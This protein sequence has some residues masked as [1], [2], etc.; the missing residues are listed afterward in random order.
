MLQ[1]LL[2]RG[3]SYDDI[4]SLLG[5]SREDVRRKAR[6][7]LEELG[8]RDPDAE[9]GLSD[10]LLGQ[11]DPIGR[12]DVVRHLQADPEA[13]G[14]AGELSAK[15]RLLAPEAELPDLPQPKKRRGA[16][17]A[18]AGA[19]PGAPS[20]GRESEEKRSPIAGLSTRQSRLIAI[21]GASAVIVLIA[22]VA[23]LSGG[24][25]GDSNSATSDE[26]EPDVDRIEF[27]AQSG[28]GASGE[29]IIGFANQTTPFLELDLSGLPEAGKG[30]A[31]V[32]W[33]LG[34]EET[35]LPLPQ[36]L[37]VDKNG[38]Y[39][40]RLPIN[41]VVGPV[42]LA[43]QF[44]GISLV[45][46]EQFVQDLQASIG[47]GDTVVPYGGESVLLGEL[48]T[49]SP[50]LQEFLTEQ[51]AAGAGAQGAAPP[52]GGAVPPEGGGQAAPDD[53]Q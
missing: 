18:A 23:I 15:L 51:T 45:K 49:P 24:D 16:S 40:E 10:Y 30:Q 53:A 22:I 28:S 21:I 35:G 9:V 43:S 3:Q 47:Q 33:F 17:P 39:S 12:A 29:A 14:L 48:P 37:P 46:E 25:G 36:A 26:N 38:N 52:A 27:E 50:E 8:G 13:L 42:I 5:E 41:E 31:Y 34:D 6:G 11:A 44:I 4:A 1:L 7:A 32:L 20:G 2:E 19:E